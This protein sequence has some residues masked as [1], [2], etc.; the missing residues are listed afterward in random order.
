MKKDVIYRTKN[1]EKYPWRRLVYGI[2]K[3]YKIL[4]EKSSSDKKLTTA[5]LFDDT[6]I[7]KSGCK[8]EKTSCVFDHT[9]NKTRTNKFAGVDLKIWQWVIMMEQ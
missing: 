8:I 7:M 5:I 3:I 4:T 9:T 1:N 6:S 2:V